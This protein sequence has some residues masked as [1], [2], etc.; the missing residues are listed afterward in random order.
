MASPDTDHDMEVA[1]HKDFG[2]VVDHQERWVDQHCWPLMWREMKMPVLTHVVALL[3]V[4]LDSLAEDH[5]NPDGNLPLGDHYCW[6][7]V[8]HRW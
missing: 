5:N 6:G 2:W 8:D 7:E 3:V 4:C 1:V